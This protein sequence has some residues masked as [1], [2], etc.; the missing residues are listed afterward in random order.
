MN[1]Q[2][3]N[4]I[5]RA[6]LLA[7]GKHFDNKEPIRKGCLNTQCFCTGDCQEIVGWRDKPSLLGG[8]LPSGEVKKEESHF[9]DIEPIRMCK[10]PSHNPPTHLHIPQGK[11]Y[12]HIC[13]GCNAKMTLQPP[14]IT[15]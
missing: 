15:L 2:K 7:I 3:E 8:I 1:N 13:P 10:H 12:V 5:Y 9:E 6:S 4:P 11:R 14:Q